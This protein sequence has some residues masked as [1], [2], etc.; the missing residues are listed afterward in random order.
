MKMSEGNYKYASDM[1]DDIMSDLQTARNYYK[2][3]G[4]ISKQMKIDEKL[5]E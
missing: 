1:I 4:D 2:V 3:T 5:I